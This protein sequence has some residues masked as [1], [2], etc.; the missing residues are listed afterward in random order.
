[1]KT[2]YQYLYESSSSQEVMSILIG[3]GY[4]VKPVL[5]SGKRVA[6]VTDQR[7]EALNAAKDALSAYNPVLDTSERARRISSLGVLTLDSG[8]Q[9]IAKPA[10]RNVLKAE[11]E[12]TQALI[13]ILNDAIDQTGS[14]IDVLVG[15]SVLRDVVTAGADHIRG[16]PKADIALMDSSDREVG[17]ISHK[18]EGGASGFQQYGGIS[19]RAGAA[20]YNNQLVQEFIKDLAEY[21]ED[22]TGTTSARRGMSAWRP[23]PSTRE[24]ENLVGKS[25][26]G[27]DWDRGRTFNRQS[28]HCIGQGS[29]VLTLERPQVYR[30]TFSELTHYPDDVSWAFSGDYRAI[31]AATFRSNR[32]VPGH[33]G[34]TIDNMRAGIYPYDFIKNRRAEQL[35]EN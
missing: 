7:R 27:P 12:A 23:I 6:I 3:L 1:M 24:G 18:K 11:Q 28:V 15:K 35:H 5:R 10:S 21:V 17:F 9:I 33:E 34:V 26:F 19:P 20:I 29:P 32:K 25:A 8:I 31:F 30:L 22:E 13:S 2:F 4:E 16:D 14:P